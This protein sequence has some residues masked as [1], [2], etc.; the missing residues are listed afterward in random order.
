MQVGGMW[1]LDFYNDSPLAVGM[2]SERVASL[3]PFAN[4][5]PDS[6]PGPGRCLKRVACQRKRPL[7]GASLH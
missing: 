5:N 3:F 4:P 1:G 7:P 2:A 6:N